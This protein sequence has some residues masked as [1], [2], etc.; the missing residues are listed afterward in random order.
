[1]R[2]R[3]PT[4]EPFINCQ[5]AMTFKATHDALRRS[6]V[7]TR[8]NDIALS[9]IVQDLAIVADRCILAHQKI[10]ELLALK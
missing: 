3:S 10:I 4:D 8:C 1:M 5:S 9:N 2:V 7:A 6:F